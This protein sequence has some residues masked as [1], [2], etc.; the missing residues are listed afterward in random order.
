[1]T[2]STIPSS[3]IYSTQSQAFT[4]GKPTICQ[5]NNN[6]IQPC[7]IPSN[8]QQQQPPHHQIHDVGPPNTINRTQL[9]SVVNF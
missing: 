7:M 9:E 4:S 3:G 1:M 2:T 5:T 6:I 8:Q